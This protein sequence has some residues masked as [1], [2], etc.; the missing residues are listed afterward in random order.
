MVYPYRGED[1]ECAAVARAT[2][3]AN[4]QQHVSLFDESMGVYSQTEGSVSEV[5]HSEGGSNSVSTALLVGT[6]YNPNNPSSIDT[7][8]MVSSLQDEPFNN[9]PP[10]HNQTPRLTAPYLDYPTKELTPEQALGLTQSS[11]PR[12]RLWCWGV[13]F[14]FTLLI[15]IA[16]SMG[17]IIG[18][19]HEK[20]KTASIR[21]VPPTAAVDPAADE[22]DSTEE[23]GVNASD[24]TE[25][26]TAPTA[27]SS[28]S[29]E[30]TY[31]PLV[32]NS[33]PNTTSHAINNLVRNLPSYTQQA[34]ETPTSPQ[35]R[36]LNW[37]TKDPALVSY[38]AA[39]L[40]QRFV[41]KTFYYAT[42]GDNDEF[43]SE[44]Q[45]L[46]SDG[47][48]SSSLSSSNEHECQWF[49][50]YQDDSIEP[51]CN[52]QGV[53]TVLSVRRNNL[54]GSLPMELA[55]LTSLR[56]LDLELNS[57]QSDIPTELGLMTNLERL[58]LGAN[59]LT[60]SVPSQLGQLSRLVE[61][62][63]E[64][65]ALSSSIPIELGQ[66]NRLVNLTLDD[67]QVQGEIPSELGQLTHLENL[68]LHGNMLQGSI[69][70]QAGQWSQLL[71]LS[72][73]NNELTGSLPSQLGLLTNLERLWAY[74]NQLSGSIPSHLCQATRLTQLSLSRNQLT[75][76]LPTQIA[77]L[78][79]LKNL[80]LY[81]NQ[82]TGSLPS[83]L[84]LL[85]ELELLP[86][87]DNDFHGSVPQEVCAIEALEVAVDCAEVACDCDCTCAGDEE[88]ND[89]DADGEK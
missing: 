34:L 83:Q 12:R 7:N 49:T 26:A 52:D 31:A 47:W 10:E 82:L 60:G 20:G 5:S 3:V 4:S 39:Q 76:Q 44:Q 77:L 17:V 41:L 24:F 71:S 81:A 22:S 54:R 2:M 48:S 11:S 45:W 27:P 69:P 73:R 29:D 65:N 25:S 14:A 62:E 68:L 16:V 18:V 13:L 1:M 19:N 67:N 32:E 53:Y 85:T 23:A 35:Q 38:T 15:G 57:I 89:I 21:G 59:D 63:L 8:S 80:W 6:F 84:G 56:V 64:N 79:G 9:N 87:R 51:A 78:T 58:L 50:T 33:R 74:Q 46:N 70:S 61:L 88:A 72:L 66:L 36:A 28:S 37:L 86:V 40:L 42:N 75:G 30:P 55:L 43:D